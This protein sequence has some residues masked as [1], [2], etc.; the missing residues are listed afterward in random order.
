MFYNNPVANQIPTFELTDTKLYVPVVI[1]SAQD[2]TKLLQ[3]LKSGVKRIFYCKK[4]QSKVTI[5]ERNR[6]LD[7]LIDP[8]FQGVNRLFVLSFENNTG[9]TSYKEYFLPKIEVKDYN[10]AVDG[11]KFFDF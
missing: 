9:R 11:R 3:Q 2:N 8:G 1:L 7:Y 4:Y 6:Y 5:Q 10:V